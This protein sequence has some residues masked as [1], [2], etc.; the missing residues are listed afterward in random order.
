MSEIQWIINLMM[1]HKLPEAVKNLC[2]ERIGEVE[3]RIS[4]ETNKPT[5]PIQHYAVLSGAQGPQQ[6]A[7]TLAAMARQETNAQSPLIHN[8]SLPIQMPKEVITGGGNMTS[9]KGPNKMR[10]RL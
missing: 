5:G 6:S 4:I 9:I 10:G 2:I 1:K 7:S 8:A 3:A